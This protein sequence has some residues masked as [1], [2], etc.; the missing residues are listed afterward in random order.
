MRK[1]FLTG[2]LALGFLA[3][4][5]GSGGGHS[6]THSNGYAVSKATPYMSSP[7][8][9]MSSG[10]PMGKT[11][12]GMALVNAQ[13]HSLYLFKKDT[14]NTS[15]C[16]GSCATAWP[17]LISSGKP[18]AASGVSA[19]WLGTTKR[20]DGKMQVTYAGQPLY[21]FAGDSKPGDANGQDSKAFGATWYLVGANGKQIGA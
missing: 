4:A 5:C 21:T 13:G 14:K 18:Q 15:S 17:P 8:P 6:T 9:S 19:S 7:A 10:N 11:K 3:A 1:M 12:F 2:T 20:Q 16:S